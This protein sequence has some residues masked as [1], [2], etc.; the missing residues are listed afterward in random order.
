MRMLKI[1]AASKKLSLN[2]H[3]LWDTAQVRWIPHPLF[4]LVYPIQC[5][6]NLFLLAFFLP[7][8]AVASRLGRADL[9]LP[10]AEIQRT[11][12][13]QLLIQWCLDVFTA[14]I[15]PLNS[16]GAT[17][18]KSELNN[19][20]NW[21]VTFIS[22]DFAWESC[23]GFHF[24]TFVYDWWFVNRVKLKYDVKKYVKFGHVRVSLCFFFVLPLLFLWEFS[25]VWTIDYRC[26]D[27]N[28]TFT[29][30]Q[31]REAKLV[32]SCVDSILQKLRPSPPKK[33]NH[34]ARSSIWR[35]RFQALVWYC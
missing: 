11:P 16:E 18:L 26:Q 23:S 10:G 5:L 34:S 35:C 2:N 3:R 17:C 8:Q 25:R 21:F 31:V 14:Q 4:G 12:P 30:W 27:K 22:C 33:T 20:Q 6:S 28:E 19:A 7:E 13:A 9:W 29:S 24:L 15:V 1:R 32:L